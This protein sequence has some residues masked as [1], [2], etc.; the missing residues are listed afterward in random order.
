MTNVQSQNDHTNIC[1]Y[2]NRDMS[3]AH[4]SLHA[5]AS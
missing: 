1:T 5:F 4:H 2:C 3:D